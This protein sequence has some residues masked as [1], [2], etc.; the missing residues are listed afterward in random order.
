MHAALW[1][2]AASLTV[3]GLISFVGIRNPSGDKATS[4]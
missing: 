3:G 1:A 4:S 2:M